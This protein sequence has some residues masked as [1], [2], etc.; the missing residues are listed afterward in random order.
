MICPFCRGEMIPGGLHLTTR[1][2]HP[3]PIR[4]VPLD[5]NTGK[6]A[7]WG[8]RKARPMVGS[9]DEKAAG[10]SLEEQL[11]SALPDAEGWYCPGCKKA[12]G[13]FLDLDSA[14]FP[15]PEP[16]DTLWPYRRRK[17]EKPD[18]ED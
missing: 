8:S 14:S 3:D 12:V 1:P 11:F 2:L 10:R 13:I 17:H 5:E 4:W 15:S 6:Y 7:S 18:W 16:G 9:L